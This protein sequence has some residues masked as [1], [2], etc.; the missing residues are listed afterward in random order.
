M[1]VICSL[2]CLDN[3]T[4]GLDSSTSLEFIELMREWTTQSRCVTAMSVYQ[5]SD[6]IMPYFDKVLVINSGRQIFYGKVH[7]AK[8]Y[9]E[10]LGFEC[11]PT[12]TVSDFLNS[13]SA[14]PEVRRV[15]EGKQH[16]VPRTPDEFE[17]AFRASRFYQEM[18]TSV[19]MAKDQ[20][21]NSPS[22]LVKSPAFSLP[23][24]LQIW[25]CACRQFRIVTSDYSLWAVEPATIIVQSLVLG[26]LFRDQQRTTRSL[27]IFASA[28]F[29]SVLVPALQSMAE[30][31][32]GF[33]QRPLI[34]K[35]KRYRICR[36]I[37]Y[38]LGL[39]TTDVVWKIAAIG[40]NIP[41][42]FLTGFQRTA[43]NFFTWFFIVYLEHLALSMFFRSVAVFSPNMHRAVLPVGI[44]FNMYV[45]YTGLYVPA[46]QMQV[47][48][49][50]LRYLN[51]RRCQ[52]PP[53]P[54]YSGRIC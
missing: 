26:T 36:P 54:L 16:Q 12:T 31:G 32:N 5:A 35:Q 49:G 44:F 34:L 18:R 33:A 38:A 10:N 51:V 21:R 4:H 29:Y 9:F 13:M 27:F 42:Y 52:S 40:Y 47:W 3:P 20:A 25:Y 1:S 22:P 2:I 19:Q 11:L 37:A 24:Y 7:E 46:P 14:D 8:A 45:L 50:W 23:L 39:V 30:F 15:H 17:D 48:L 41:L 53:R 6:A 43:G 28:L